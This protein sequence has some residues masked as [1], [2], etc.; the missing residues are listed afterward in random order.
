MMVS[1]VLAALWASSMLVYG[2]ELPLTLLTLRIFALAAIVMQM[3]ARTSN[4]F[5][6]SLKF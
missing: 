4:V 3:A 5:F 2:A 1:P 6:I